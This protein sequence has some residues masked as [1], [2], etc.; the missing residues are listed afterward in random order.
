MRYRDFRHTSKQHCEDGIQENE[1]FGIPSVM[2]VELDQTKRARL[3]PPQF[4]LDE[5]RQAFRG[6]P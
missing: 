4:L 3:I 6:V 1:R 2:C 5:G